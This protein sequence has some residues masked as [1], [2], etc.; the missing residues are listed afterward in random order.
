MAGD[1][2][3]DLSYG[4]HFF[5]DL[6]ETGIAYVALFPESDQCLYQPDQ[7]AAA[8][9]AQTTDSAI[10]VYDLANYPLQMTG[11]IVSQQL[12]CFRPA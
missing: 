5:Q 2:V 1:M 8:S 12:V 11:D 10:H 4:S 9:Q 7:F 3:P 6:V